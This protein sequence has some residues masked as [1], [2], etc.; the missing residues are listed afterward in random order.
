[1]PQRSIHASL[2]DLPAGYGTITTGHEKQRGLVEYPRMVCGWNTL[3]RETIRI[4]CPTR[5]IELFI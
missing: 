5:H 4:A 1:M 2:Q 3:L